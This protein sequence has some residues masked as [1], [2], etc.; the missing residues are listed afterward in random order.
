MVELCRFNV[1]EERRWRQKVN[2]LSLCSH[3][4]LSRLISLESSHTS[5]SGVGGQSPIPRDS[6]SE[7][8]KFLI[9]TLVPKINPIEIQILVPFK[10]PLKMCSLMKQTLQVQAHQQSQMRLAQQSNR[11]LKLMKMVFWHCF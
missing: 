11:V 8:A 1:E 10:F 4:H 9:P 6:L 7:C 5:Y 3:P 2:P